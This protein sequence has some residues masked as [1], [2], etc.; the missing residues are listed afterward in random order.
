VI[1]LNISIIGNFKIWVLRPIINGPGLTL[2]GLLLEVIPMFH[3]QKNS[4]SISIMS[5]QEKFSFTF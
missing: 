2:I 1:G 4:L 5:R 3:T